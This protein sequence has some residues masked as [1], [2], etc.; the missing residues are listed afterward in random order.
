[1]SHV[2]QSHQPAP[3]MD[4]VALEKANEWAADMMAQIPGEASVTM[5]TRREYH[6][7]LVLAYAMGFK[8]GIG[9][10]DELN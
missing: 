9:W 2:H 10:R 3:N 4:E 1:M 6:E 5:I 8:R 7:L